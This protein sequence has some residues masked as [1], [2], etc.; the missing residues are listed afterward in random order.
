MILLKPLA[1]LTPKSFAVFFDLNLS[2]FYT[3]E[4]MNYSVLK[5]LILK[6]LCSPGSTSLFFQI[7][8]TC[9]VLKYA[10]HIHFLATNS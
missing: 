1:P 2:E 6:L 8:F 7:P 3:K 10:F 5:K 9:Q 4:S